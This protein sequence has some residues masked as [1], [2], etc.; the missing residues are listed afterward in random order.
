[1]D[2]LDLF[3]CDDVIGVQTIPTAGANYTDAKTVTAV[4]AALVKKGY[5]LGTSGPNGDGVD[6]VFGSKTKAAI[7]KLQATIG[8]DVNGRIDE[9]VIAALGVTPGVLPPGVTAA[10]RAAVQ[11][12]LALDAA[13]AAEHANTPADVQ[14]AAQQAYDAAPAEPAALKDAAAAALQKSR[15]AVTPAD[16]KKAAEAVKQAAM[17]A[18]EEVK[19]P[20]F[21]SPAW[22]GG[23][24]QWKVGAVAVGGLGIVGGILAA[25][26]K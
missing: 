4:Q 1:M 6:G 8:A 24:E 23:P 20:W 7:K 2:G 21:K 10:G 3:G 25:V 15:S 9:G 19:L 12:Q 16:V 17:A 14:A 22:P 13:A 26:I 11:A 18:Y 5:D